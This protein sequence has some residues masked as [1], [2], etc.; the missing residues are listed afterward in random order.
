MPLF[1]L[2][3][4]AG[5]HIQDGR[6]Y[7]AGEVVESDEDLCTLF[8]GKFD[9]IDADAPP[10]EPSTDAKSPKSKSKGRKAAKGQK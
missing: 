10:V 8:A 1:L 7:R 9:A 6:E 5:R 4:N 3:E 2:R